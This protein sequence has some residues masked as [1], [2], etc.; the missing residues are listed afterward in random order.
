MHESQPRLLAVAAVLGLIVGLSGVVTAEEET[1]APLQPSPPASGPGSPTTT[2]PEAVWTHYGEDPGG[3]WI[4][5]PST[6]PGAVTLPD[7]TGPLPLVVFITGCCDEQTQLTDVAF[8]ESWIS[9]VTRQ[10]MVVISPVY[11]PPKAGYDSLRT[12]PEIQQLVQDA[13]VELAGEGH[14]PVDTSRNG[15]IAVSFG[16]VPGIVYTSQ[17]AS[18]GLPVP[19]GLFIHAPCEDSCG[20]RV[21]P[22]TTMPDGLK[23]VEMTFE[24]DEYMPLTTQKR[25]YELFL[26]L[27]PENRDFVRMYRDDH[28]DPR[29][30]ADHG[31]GGNERGTGEY[32]GVWT[33]S[34]A[35]MTCAIDGVWCEY[36]LGATPEQRS[37]GTWSDGVP[38]K[39]LVVVDDPVDLES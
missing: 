10:G 33:L 34:T 3:F 7:G 12:V 15:V 30:E 38:V 17:A 23:V 28:G 21:P 8:L 2:Y 35:L 36:A 32:Y 9:H 1:T 20:V 27:P 6:T 14:P 22:G 29:V 24:H 25:V 26:S 39:E 18:V 31:E 13:L 37:M 4:I 5:A 19:Q 16:G 11:S